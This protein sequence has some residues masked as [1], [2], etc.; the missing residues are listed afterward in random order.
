MKEILHTEK[1]TYV[2]GQ[3]CDGSSRQHDIRMGTALT[4]VACSCV[5]DCDTSVS[6]Q[7]WTRCPAS[8]LLVSFSWRKFMFCRIGQHNRK[9]N[10]LTN[11]FGLIYFGPAVQRIKTSGLLG[12][13]LRE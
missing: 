9:Q 4:L 11:I 6:F 3:C 10:I 7:T 8:F 12:C 2:G 1:M 5:H 13:A